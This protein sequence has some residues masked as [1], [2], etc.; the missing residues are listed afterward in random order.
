MTKKERFRNSKAKDDYPFFTINRAKNILRKLKISVV[1]K[2]WLNQLNNF[3]SVHLE[4]YNTNIGVNG[5]GI[6]S[7]YALASAYGELMER[8]QNQILYTHDIDFDK[9]INEKFGFIFSPDERALIRRE[10]LNQLPT[11]FNDILRSMSCKNNPLVKNNCFIIGNQEDSS[12]SQLCLPFYNINENSIAY[13]PIP[14]IVNHYDSNGMAAGNSKEEA[15]VQCLFEIF[16]RY[17][18][19]TALENNVVFP[20]IPDSYMRQYKKQYN[21]IKKFEMETNQKVIVKDASLGKKLPVVAIVLLN[22]EKNSFRVKFGSHC[23][24][25]I[26]LERCFTE[27][28]QG[29][30]IDE[31]KW[32][33]RFKY[34]RKNESKKLRLRETNKDYSE[35]YMSIHP[36][37]FFNKKHSYN[38]NDLIFQKFYANKEILAYYLNLINKL[39]F[40]IFCR[41]VSFLG[42]PA[43][44]I[45]IPGM[46]E[47]NSFTLGQCGEVD[48]KKNIREIIR[49]RSFIE[50]DNKLKQIIEYILD[51]YN[52]LD[53]LG[54]IVGLP[55]DEDFPLKKIPYDL[56][57]FAAYYHLGDIENAIEYL[58]KY[59]MSFCLNNNKSRAIYKKYSCIRDILIMKIENNKNRHIYNFLFPMYGKHLV[60]RLL[61]VLSDSKSLFIYFPKISC[62]D[63]RNCSANKSCYYDEI[64][65]IQIKI[66]EQIKNNYIDQMSCEQPHRI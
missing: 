23:F 36:N 61:D 19:R 55:V 39:G 63:C 5:K 48:S 37:P 25:E 65:K 29:N 9:E 60:R 32:Y 18:Y 51:S 34:P 20:T 53:T 26:A 12:K 1:E 27:L 4:I 54:D 44:Q 15:L 66:K 8:L 16:E 6:N 33:C 42:F 17:S 47:I 10:V 40:N 45:I 62:W 14:M 21:F 46:S 41:D 57:L 52:K 58:E 43:Y 28:L 50:S 31:L 59:L 13:F 38:F 7:E 64:K 24:F 30:P 22:L 35:N 56:F 3:Y 49:T 11:E 2:R